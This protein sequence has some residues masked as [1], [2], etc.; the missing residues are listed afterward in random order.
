MVGGSV[1]GPV[2]SL[3]NSIKVGSNDATEVEN[4]EGCGDAAVNVGVLD[5]CEG[6]SEGAKA[7]GLE[8]PSSKGLSVGCFGVLSW[9]D[10]PPH[11]VEVNKNNR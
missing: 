10:V 5:D 7:G 2:Q 11:L 1:G 9:A 6:R 3:S 8:T 4:V